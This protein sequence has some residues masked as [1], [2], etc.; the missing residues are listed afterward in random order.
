MGLHGT[1]AKFL[2]QIE[3]FW[4]QVIS[5][6]AL[7]LIMDEKSSWKDRLTDSL[8][9]KTKGN[10]FRSALVELLTIPGIKNK[11]ACM[12]F[13]LFP[14]REYMQVRYGIAAGKNLLPFY[15]RRITDAFLGIFR[16]NPNDPS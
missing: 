16:K 7:Q 6:N 9:E 15:F 8:V 10:R 2:Q 4:P 14:D 1:A 3:K 11:L 12:T 13:Q 5:R